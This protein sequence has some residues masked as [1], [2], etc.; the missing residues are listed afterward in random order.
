MGGGGV[1]AGE[2]AEGVILIFF[3]YAGCS[4]SGDASSIYL[5]VTTSLTGIFF[6]FLKKNKKKKC[7]FRQAFY[8]KMSFKIERSGWLGFV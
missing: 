6:F 1:G 8:E 3:F 7:V 4:F 5:P 2:G